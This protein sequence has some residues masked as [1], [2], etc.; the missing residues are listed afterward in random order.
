MV[1]R[2]L[3][4]RRRKP[5]AHCPNLLGGDLAFMIVSLLLSLWEIWISVDALNLERDMATGRSAETK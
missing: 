5:S 4:G 2:F 3:L 1:R